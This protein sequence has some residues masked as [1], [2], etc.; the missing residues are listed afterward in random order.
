M[1]QRQTALYSGPASTLPSSNLV[2]RLV[3][4]QFAQSCATAVEVHTLSSHWCLKAKRSAMLRY[5][6]LR[7]K[8]ERSTMACETTS[9]EARLAYHATVATIRKL[10]TSFLRVVIQQDLL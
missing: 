8:Q 6:L 4:K 5:I 9:L 2:P 1:K 7:L 3:K 10:P